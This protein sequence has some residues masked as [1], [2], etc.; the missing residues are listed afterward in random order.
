MLRKGVAPGTHLLIG[1]V[2]ADAG[3]GEDSWVL[4][5]MQ[6]AVA[7][8]ADVVSMS[9]GGDSDDGSHPLS[10]AVNELSANSDTLFV[11]AAGNNG[12]NGPS[13]VSSPGS[14][15][16][17]L[18]VGAVDVNDVM[19][20][21]SSRGPRLNNGAFK[22]EVVAPGVD[23][24]AARAAGTDLGGDLATDP[25]YT[26]IS[27]TSMATPHVAGLA[28]ILKGEHPTWDGEKLKAALANSTV[29]IADATGFDAGTGRI[30]AL[31]AIHQTV[32][33]PATL[34]LGNYAWPYSDLSPSS[35]TLTYTN[36]G[37]AAVT[38]ALVPRRAR[39]APRSRPAR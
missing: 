29:P 7:Q 17:A 23:V 10:Q 30:D 22:P 1:K 39:T 33:A 32:F 35:K 21:F 13:T 36:D 34:E 15:D 4:A 14:A 9:L 19:A 16:A 3:Y 26:T 37:D 28:A 18:T 27:G 20:P 8:H 5:G 31:K 11:I 6:W 2:L 38:L 24:T 25:Y 12:N